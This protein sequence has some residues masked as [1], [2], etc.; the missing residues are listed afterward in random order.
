MLAE[1]EAELDRQAKEAAIRM[2]RVVANFHRTI[3]RIPKGNQK[4]DL[5]GIEEE[6]SGDASEGSVQ[7]SSSK[8]S[9]EL[10]QGDDLNIFRSQSSL[11]HS[12]LSRTNTR[13]PMRLETNQDFDKWQPSLEMQTIKPLEE[14][15]A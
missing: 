13:T 15:I 12:K 5:S 14:L 6:K 11:S 8:L 3:V 1:D 4:R 2:K 9:K 10:A 7:D